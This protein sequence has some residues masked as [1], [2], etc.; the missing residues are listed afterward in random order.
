MRRFLIF[1]LALLASTE[2]SASLAACAIPQGG[3]PSLRVYPSSSPTPTNTPKPTKTPTPIATLTPT[4][5]SAETIFVPEGFA[6]ADGG[7]LRNPETGKDVLAFNPEADW[8]R[9]REEIIGGLWEANVDWTSYTGQ[10]NDAT[11]YTREEFIKAALEGNKFHIG[12]PVRLDAKNIPEDFERGRDRFVVFKMVDIMLDNIQIQI[13]SPDAFV[14][15]TGRGWLETGQEAY[16]CASYPGTGSNACFFTTNADRLMVS[17]GSFYFGSQI[18]SSLQ[19][20]IGNFNPEL[21]EKYPSYFRPDGIGI[22]ADRALSFTLGYALD[23]L[24][25]FSLAHYKFTAPNGDN[26]KIISIGKTMGYPDEES[27]LNPNLFIFSK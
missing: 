1:V 13:L 18:I 3:S 14:K 5:A 20:L 19:G 12:I 9:V 2:L 27:Y 16:D 21:Y 4:E 8:E 7:L 11:K 6:I 23:E 15:Y 10:G 17:I 26:I 24:D 22:E 25:F